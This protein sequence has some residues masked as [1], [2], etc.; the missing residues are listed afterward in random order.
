M[1]PLA[2]VAF[3]SV[4]PIEFVFVPVWAILGALC[5]LTLVNP[6][7]AFRYV[8]IFQ[9]RDVELSTFGIVWHVGGALI[10]LAFAFPYVLIQGE[11]IGVISAVT[12][13]GV[14][15]GM[16]VRNWPPAY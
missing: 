10:T 5:G 13:Y 3:L 4:D 7:R 8:N 14:A 1:D 2:L 9:L 15:V 11:P 16:F 12:F 6:E